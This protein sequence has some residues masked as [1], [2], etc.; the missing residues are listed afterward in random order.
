SY[1]ATKMLVEG[2]SKKDSATISAEIDQFGAF[3]DLHA[4]MD[5]VVV[6]LACLSKHLNSLLP[7]LQQIIY[8][9]AFPE[10]EYDIL[11]NIKTQ[12]VR[13]NNEKNSVLASKKLREILFGEDHPYGR[14]LSVEAIQELAL[15]NVKKFYLDSFMGPYQLILSGNP[16]KDT[17]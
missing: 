13:V 6:T 7:L 8:D 2:T 15:D 1:F 12:Q 10:K 16:E 4:S 14:E 17:I 5:Y 3:I 9:A 11:K